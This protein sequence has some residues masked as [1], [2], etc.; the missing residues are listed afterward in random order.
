MLDS[1]I[2]FMAITF[3]VITIMLWRPFGVNETIPTSAGAVLVLVLGIVPF[4]DIKDIFY[5]VSGASLT[6]LSTIMM[7]IVLDSIGFFK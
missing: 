1:D 7:S 6:I 5:I 3:V 2:F 4:D